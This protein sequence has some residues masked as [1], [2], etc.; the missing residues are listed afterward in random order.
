M[1]QSPK[2][3]CTEYFSFIRPDFILLCR[4]YM[5]LFQLHTPTCFIINQNVCNV[6]LCPSPFLAR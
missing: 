5:V 6:A 2:Q 1:I 4:T 3:S